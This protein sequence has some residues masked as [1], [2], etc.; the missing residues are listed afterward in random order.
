MTT[1]ILIVDDE[2]AIRQILGAA[3]KTA[4]YAIDEAGSGEEALAR[5]ATGEIDVVLCDICLP[6]LSGI[7]VLTRTRTLGVDTKFIMITA[8]ASMDTAIEAMRA[9]A[10]DYIIKPLC[11]E[12]VLHRLRQVCELK[13]MRD[14]NR[15]LRKLVTSDADQ[16]YRF[17]SLAMQEMERLAKKVAPTDGTILITGESGVGKNVIAHDIHQNSW[18]SE[19]LFLPVNCGAIPDTL[20]ESELFGHTKGA[21]TSADKARKGLFLQAEGGSILLDEIGDLPLP[22]Q[23]KLL[24]VLEE[25]QFRAVG[26]ERM[27]KADVRIIAATNRNL[28]EMVTAKSFREDLYFRLNAIHIDVPPLRELRDDIPGLVQFVLERCAT[29]LAPKRK[30]AIDP[31]A[32]ELLVSYNWPGNIRELRNVVESAFILAEGDTITIAD[33]PNEIGGVHRGGRGEASRFARAIGDLNH[34]VRAFE[35]TLLTQAL[36]E[37]NG[38]RRMAAQRLGI[39]VSTLYRKLEEFNRLTS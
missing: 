14:E 37:A 8:F 18:R 2:L 27:Q 24:Q 26:S 7:D 33:L 1:Q 25:K 15:M 30:L 6:D 29:R 35:A 11:H 13:N 39:G 20:V 31:L 22:V 16:K 34:Q 28:S 5:L 17:K 4:G 12:E 23:S 38:D 19:A 36:Q 9:G 3:L 10:A 21:F 32:E